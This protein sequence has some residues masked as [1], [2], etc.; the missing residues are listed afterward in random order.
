VSA[1][2]A[3]SYPIVMA[4]IESKAQHIPN[5]LLVALRA[6]QDKFMSSPPKSIMAMIMEDDQQILVTLGRRALDI[7][8]MVEMIGFKMVED[9]DYMK[10]NINITDECSITFVSK[11]LKLLVK[12]QNW[13]LDLI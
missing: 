13:Q 5:K 1:M 12:Q 8:K 11:N 6:S 10:F 3:R 7:S 2:D 4:I 9:S